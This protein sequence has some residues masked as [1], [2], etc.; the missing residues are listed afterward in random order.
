[1]FG[2]KKTESEILYTITIGAH[3]YAVEEGVYEYLKDLKRGLSNAKH[4]LELIKPDLESGKLRP[5]VSEWCRDC[6]FAHV[7]RYNGQVLGCRKGVVC[8]DYMSKEE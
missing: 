4:E 7:S 6:K 2:K 5:A 1:M 8:D 3:T